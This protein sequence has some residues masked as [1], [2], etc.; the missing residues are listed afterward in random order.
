MTGSGDTRALQA[1][2]SGQ[3]TLLA[4]VSAALTVAML[5]TATAGCE[6]S[7]GLV[8]LIPD[9]EVAPEAGS[10]LLFEDVVLGV[11]GP[12]EPRTITIRNAGTGPLEISGVSIVDVGSDSALSGA[13]QFR[14]S[15]FP[16][17]LSPGAEGL[18][19]V[20][21][22][23]TI[24]ATASARLLLE[25]NDPDER[26]LTF[27]LQGYARDPCRLQAT[28]SHQVFILNEVKDVTL[29]SAS[30]Y[31][32][33][34]N[35]L[36]TDESLF[37]LID[38]PEMPFV[39]EAGESRTLD[40]QHSGTTIQP[41]VPIRQLRVRESEGTER[42]VSFE[43]EPPIFGCLEITPDRLN[44]G[45]VPLDQTRDQLVRV[46][47]RCRREATL[48]AG[49]VN[50][51]FYAYSILDTFPLV[52]PPRE[53][54]NLTVQ[55][56]PLLE[57]GDRGRLTILTND[58]QLPRREIEL[59]GEAAQ[60]LVD[61]FPK[62]QDFGTVAYRQQAGTTR[63]E[64]SSSSREVT[65]VST[66]E[67]PVIIN[68]LAVEAGGDEFFQ[69]ASVTINRCGADTPCFEPV[70]FL[71]PI[72]LTLGDELQVN[73]VFSPSRLDP[74][75][76]QAK[77]VLEHNAQGG[78][79]EVRLLGR[80]GTDGA[81]EDVFQQLPGPKVD[82][83]WVIDNSCSMFDEQARL[84]ANLSQFVGF[85][86]ALQS[87]YQMAVTTT[88]ATS[89]SAGDFERCFPH[90]A[91]VG[92]SYAD[93]PTREAAFRCM[94]DVGTNGNGRIEA[95]WGA[96]KKSLERALD[97]NLEPNPN[98]AFLRD[99]ANLVVVSVSDEDDQ[100]FEA[101][102]VLRDFFFSVKDRR[103]P[104]RF[105]AHAI[106]FPVAEPCL[107][108]SNFGSPGFGYS[109]MARETGGIFF[110]LCDTDWSP[111]IQS[112]AETTFVPIDEWDLSRQADPATI[113]VLVNGV[114]VAADSSNGWSYD[115]I[116]N[117]VKFN[118]T[119]LPEPGADI[120]IDYQGLCR[121]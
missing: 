111:I 71:R 19:F 18:L 65:V 105:K 91:I 101:D 10:R 20:R 8:S 99:D 32:C 80:G 56:V 62:E 94:F 67:S 93:Q 60:A 26:Q 57:T 27:V 92:S 48:V 79:D 90:P 4:R 42:V 36:A 97:P 66:G 5:S 68:S 29:T 43:G 54:V 12:A 104:D 118:G 95:G 59:D 58:A 22:E 116:G 14:V 109:W 46:R 39:I 83:L 112:I 114:P 117:S 82:I 87:D 47:N 73:L 53:T 77:L 17:V 121:P 25:S 88:D 28:P 51:A 75:L 89:P 23:P 35:S 113:D 11:S 69:I 76:H 106:A 84:I 72:G 31:R 2:E 15:S 33:V 45:V 13:D 78:R 49:A 70:D 61:V 1:R 3:S 40:V 9:I 52:V 38:P 103:N 41:G 30:S 24:T 100:S 119:S 96:A 102:T 120:R 74:A 34:I 16:A 37:S 107:P 6:E 115:F 98:A 44:F 63:S 55:Y 81:T 110:N 86:D 7:G 64:C 50:V 108:V 21:F 85:A